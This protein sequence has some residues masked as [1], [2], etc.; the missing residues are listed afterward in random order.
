MNDSE[1]KTM[2]VSRLQRFRR[3][4]RGNVVMIFAL[5]AVP[6]IAAVGC[7]MDYGR[8]ARIH[9][10]FE[11][12]ADAASVSS[13]SLA[14]RAYAQAQSMSGDGPV[15]VGNADALSMFNANI[16]HVIDY[17]L[18]TV[19]PN[20]VMSKGSLTSTVQFTA[21]VPT[22]FMKIMG[23]NT[24]N[25]SGQ[26]VATNVVASTAYADFYMLL[27]NS[28]SMGIGATTAMSNLYKLA[29]N[30]EDGNC[31][32]ACH[33]TARPLPVVNGIQ[34][35][36]DNYE[37]ARQNKVML[38]FDEVVAG[39]QSMMNYASNYENGASWYR[40]AI[41]DYGASAS[42]I[43]LTNTFPLS[44]DLSN[45]QSATSNLSLMTVSWWGTNDD[46]DTPHNTIL[47][48]INAIIPAAGSGATPQTPK[49]ILFIVSD[50]V[51]DE[52][53]PSCST[54][55]TQPKASYATDPQGDGN[56]VLD[57][58]RSGAVPAV[59][60]PRRSSRRP[61]YDLFESGDARLSDHRRLLSGQRHA[62]QSRAVHTRVNQ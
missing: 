19:T 38:R 48:A 5:A 28:P 23:I 39:A 60:G 61:L 15:A 46:M 57:A 53:N 43:G 45:P 31:A 52:N 3:D 49:K 24:M 36:Y 56:T 10:K 58:H 55:S 17:T 54:A 62:L 34:Q 9:S 33:V 41:Y 35:V 1:G 4:Q 11:S 12:A 42:T 40:F 21:Q 26:S 44:Y 22:I 27:D 7:A 47:P 8:A 51:S 32:F 6:I 16:A 37:I 29:T 2:I 14:S 18:D 50:G 30:N 20:V 25:V 13:I 59:Q